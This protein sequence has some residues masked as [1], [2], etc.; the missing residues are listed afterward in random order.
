MSV[1]GVA[2]GAGRR[3]WIGLAVLAL[4]TLLVSFD[5]FVLLLALPHLSADLGAD[6][7]QQLWIMDIYG[8]MVGGFLITMGSLGDRIG[9]RRLLLIG[10]AAFG[11]ASVLSAYS[12]SPGMLIAARALLGVAGATLAPSTL[13]LISNMFRNPRQMGVAIG[14]WAG[15]FTVGA[16]IGPI[17]GGVMLEHFWWGSVFLLGVPVM[18]L[19]LVLGPMLLPEYRAPG[20]GRIDPLSVGLSL[21]AILPFIYGVKELA[22]SG[23]EPL[24]VVAVAAGLLF[25]VAFVRRQRVLADPLLDLSL[26]GDRAFGTTLVSLLA[27]SL[28]TGGT[29]L[30]VAQYFQSVGG[31]SPLQAG[32]GLLPGMA[33]S[34]VSVM[35]SPILARR[36]RPAYLIA[37]GLVVVVAGLLLVT[38]ADADS[39]PAILIVAFAVWALGGGPLLSLGINLVVASAPPEKAGAASAMPQISNELGAA[40]GFAVLG[41]VGIAVYRAQVADAVPPGLS[42]EAAGRA[43]ESIAG[44][45]AVAADLPGELATALLAP[46]REAFTSGVHIVAAVSAALLACTA[47]LVAVRLRHIRPVGEVESQVTG[48]RGAASEAV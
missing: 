31:L 39:G 3:E 28:L 41:S 47:L 48:D 26:F 6:G 9:R 18:A 33:A 15:S 36:I 12:T 38:L 10:A 8:F 40:L 23:W 17:V 13:A 7:V 2:P 21:A 32:L 4:G 42:A 20:S 25:A 30:F 44:A 22:R 35:V 16:I 5:V 34:T 14:V 24:P 11:V 29:M 1:N 45:T 37:A 46:A 27:Y 43:H 19:L